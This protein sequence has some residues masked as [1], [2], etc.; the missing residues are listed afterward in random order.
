MTRKKINLNLASV[1]NR[2]I[3]LG[4]IISWD[5]SASELV[6]ASNY[7]IRGQKKTGGC[8]GG[9]GAGCKL[10]EL[11]MPFNQQT[12]CSH[13]IVGCQVGNLPDCI[14]IEHSPIGCS[15]IHPRFNLGFRIGLMRRRKPVENIQIFST[16]LVERD[17]VFGASEKLRQSIR[18]AWNR[19]HPKAIF[20]SMSCSTAII[21]E[22]IESVA[23]EM[24]GD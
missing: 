17:M 11:N 21:G 23:M 7:D 20:I 13:S 2:E 15:A 16:N 1:D 8:G 24:E 10:C 3:R 6:E 22:D 4:S 9:Q 14:L 19:F 18:D 5:G 12:M